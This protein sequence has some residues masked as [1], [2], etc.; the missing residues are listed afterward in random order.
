MKQQDKKC[1][2]NDERIRRTL[3]NNITLRKEIKHQNKK[4]GKNDE[5][6]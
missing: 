5:S 1:G 3:Y 4:C 6:I 2:K